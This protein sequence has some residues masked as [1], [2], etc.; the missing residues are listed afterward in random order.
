M[1]CS[2][3]DSGGGETGFDAQVTFRAPYTGTYTAKL[4]TYS[5]G[6]TGLFSFEVQ[7]W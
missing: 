5:P 1:R 6:E 7:A 2:S 4:T 3:D